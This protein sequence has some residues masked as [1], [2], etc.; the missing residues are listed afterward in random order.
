MITAPSKLESA[1]AGEPCAYL[2]ILHRA[3]SSG[4]H[5][6]D[7]WHDVSPGQSNTGRAATYT[8]CAC[9][10][11]ARRKLKASLYEQ[12][13]SFPNPICLSCCQAKTE[14]GGFESNYRS[15]QMVAAVELDVSH[16]G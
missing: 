15:C 10:Q 13:E 14:L 9:V 6:D 2:V 8:I 16:V 1:A 5:G 12:F 3:N 4:I 7:A 11:K